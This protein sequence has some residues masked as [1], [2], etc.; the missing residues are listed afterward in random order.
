[1]VRIS[2]PDSE[3]TNPH[4]FAQRLHAPT[5]MAAAGGFSSAVYRDSALSLRE[6]EAARLRVAEINGCMICQQ[7]RSARDAGEMLAGSG[8]R[9]TRCI[10]DNGPAP[11]EA[12]VAAIPQW[13]TSGVFSERERLALEFAERFA[14]EPKVLAA[15]DDFWARMHACYSDSDIVDLSHCVAAWTGLGRVAHILGFDSACS[16]SA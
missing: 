11:D 13:R 16:V 5:I 15:D 2:I 3:M 4:A 1:M 9:P 10:A 8:A 6:F 12:F 14:E 7:F